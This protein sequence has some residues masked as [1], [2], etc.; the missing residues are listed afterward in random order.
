MKPGETLAGWL[1]DGA[2]QERTHQAALDLARRWSQHRLFRL[3]DEQLDAARPGSVDDVLVAAA[4]FMDRRLEIELLISELVEAARAD[5]F[6][7]A[8]LR[9]ASSE[10]SAGFELYA[11]PSLTL[12]LSVMSVDGL[13]AK[14]V[15]ASGAAS[16]TFG[17]RPML[18]EFIRSGGATLSFWEIPPVGPD[19]VAADSGFCRFRD[20]RTISDGER[21][22]IAADRESFVIEHACSDLVILTAA[23][24]NAGPPLSVEFDT[25]SLAFAGASSNDE[26]AS[27][28]Q[29]MVTLLRLMDRADAAPVF[30]QLLESAPFYAR[31]HVMREYLALDAEAALP[32]LRRMAAGDPHPEV[33][34]A[35]GQ[36]LASF[37]DNDDGGAAETEETQLCPA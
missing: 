23:V 37:F 26:A 1:S 20:R 17:G 27:R 16:L 7:A 32:A 9:P 15:G 13:A 12:T 14:R 22:H 24:Q 4:G 18:Y 34:V 33:R 6:F 10:I 29:M 2:R 28:I 19:F 36:V 25:R 5:P 21:I 35:A 3:L 8:P 11:H 30:E 31:W